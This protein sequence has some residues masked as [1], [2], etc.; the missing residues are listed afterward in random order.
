MAPPVAKTPITA[1]VIKR[2]RVNSSPRST[3]TIDTRKENKIPDPAAEMKN[4]IIAMK[5]TFKKVNIIRR[6]HTPTN[7]PNAINI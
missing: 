2:L 6:I 4:N 5:L 1:L 3:A 7:T